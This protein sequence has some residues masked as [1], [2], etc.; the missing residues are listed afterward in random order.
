MGFRI[1]D[2]GFKVPLNKTYATVICKGTIGCYVV[3]VVAFPYLA[4]SYEIKVSVS[5][6]QH[7]IFSLSVQD[8]TFSKDGGAC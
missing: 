5:P 1:L 8:A 2:L 6:L 7:G 3:I 4:V